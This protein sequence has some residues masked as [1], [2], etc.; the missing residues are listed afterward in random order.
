MRA[1]PDCRP[2]P[3]GWHASPPR[4]STSHPPQQ[5]EAV[6][7]ELRPGTGKGVSAGAGP[8]RRATRP[9]A[10]RARAPPPPSPAPPPQPHTTRPGPPRGG[11]PPH[12]T[13]RPANNNRTKARRISC[14]QQPPPP[15]R[16]AAKMPDEDELD[17]APHNRKN[18]QQ[19]WTSCH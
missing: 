11:R 1:A 4:T 13:S 14:R 9:A 18:D 3:T 17:C 16:D 5:Q 6:Y 15:P 2:P 19:D 12:D 8:P 7:R 10:G